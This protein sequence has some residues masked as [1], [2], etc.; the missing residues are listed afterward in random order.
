MLDKTLVLVQYERYGRIY[1]EREGRAIPFDGW[2]I[3][4][5]MVAV[6]TKRELREAI[7]KMIDDVMVEYRLHRSEIRALKYATQDGKPLKS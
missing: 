5:G 1:R 4:G 6:S 7:D 2:L 3:S